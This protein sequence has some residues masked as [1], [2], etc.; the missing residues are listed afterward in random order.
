M[1]EKRDVRAFPV[2]AAS[3][4][5]LLES[6]STPQTFSDLF[7]EARASEPVSCTALCTNQISWRLSTPARRRGGCRFLTAPW[8]QHGRVIAEK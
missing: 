4:L 5:H 6:S 3:I 7:R 2:I 1:N 8:S